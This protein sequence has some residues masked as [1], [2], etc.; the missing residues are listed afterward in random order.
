MFRVTFTVSPKAAQPES[1]HVQWAVADA[2]VQHDTEGEADT[3][4]RSTIERDGWQIE[5]VVHQ[6]HEINTEEFL[7][8]PEAMAA[9]RHAQ[10]HGIGILYYH[11]RPPNSDGGAA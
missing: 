1:A 2:F 8:N 3:V 4:T 5:D 6:S 9:I 10:E 7:S 11:V